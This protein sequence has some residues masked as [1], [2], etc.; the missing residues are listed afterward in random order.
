MTYKDVANSVLKFGEILFTPII[1]NIYNIYIITAV[2]CYASGPMKV[3]LSLRNQ[4]VPPPPPKPFHKHWYIRR[5]LLTAHF[6]QLTKRLCH[7]ML[8]LSPALRFTVGWN[9]NTGLWSK[10]A[11]LTRKVV[12]GVLYPYNSDKSNAQKLEI[13]TNINIYS[14]RRAHRPASCSVGV[15]LG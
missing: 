2:A 5:H 7:C 8:W 11:F 4:N 13:P 6:S 9:I 14:Y 12:S 3:R 15:V 1:C 10:N